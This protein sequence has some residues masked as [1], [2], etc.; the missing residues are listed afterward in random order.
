VGESTILE[1][2]G[3][4]QVLCYGENGALHTVNTRWE[5]NMELPAAENSRITAMTGMPPE[6][7]ITL[8]DGTVTV[9]SELPVQLTTL[10]T[11]EIPMVTALRPGEAVEPD[12]GRPSLILRRAGQHRLW[13]IAKASGSTVAAIQKANGLTEEPQQD[14][15]LLI[16]VS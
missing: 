4:I 11:S 1:F 2:P 3:S 10:A 9:K 14:Q 15:M 7:Q 5:G 6:P 13:D 16:P 8:G 12:P